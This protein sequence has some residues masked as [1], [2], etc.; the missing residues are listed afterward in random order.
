MCMIMIIITNY[1]DMQMMRAHENEFA[2]K[3]HTPLT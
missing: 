3:Y 2:T 1:A